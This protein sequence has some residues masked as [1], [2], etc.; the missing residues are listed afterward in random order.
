M[1]AQKIP[2]ASLVQTP[3]KNGAGSSKE[4]VAFPPG[5]GF[6]DFDWRISLASIASSAAFS[7][8]PGIDRTL[9]LVAGDGVQLEIDDQRLVALAAGAPTIAFAGELAVFA[10]VGSGPNPV[11]TDFNV[12]TK[13]SRCRHQ[14]ERLTAPQTLNRRSGTTLLFL[15]EGEQIVLR[16]GQQHVALGRFDALLLGVDDP[17]NWS[18]APAP[19]ATVFVV[20]I[21]T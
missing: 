5:A 8:F 1:M 18:F 15:A 19:G 11:S 21:F 14:F 12:M 6:D 10:T 4:I 17:V 16:G 20:D 13:R 7:V 2:Y 3:W 9:S